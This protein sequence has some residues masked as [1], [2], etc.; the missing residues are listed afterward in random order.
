MRLRA[1]LLALMVP[2]VFAAHSGAQAAP[3][4]LALVAS[5]EP[6]P[7]VCRNGECAAEFSAFCLQE[8]RASPIEGSRY[9]LYGG[10]GVRIVARTSDGQ[11]AELPADTE[12]TITTSRS[13]T[14]VRIAIDVST[15]YKRGYK[16]VAVLVGENISLLPVP[17]ANDPKPQT[18]ADIALATGPLRSLGTKVVDRAGVRV[19]AAALT[20]RMRGALPPRG[21]AGAAERDRLWQQTFGTGA[22]DLR[23]TE[24]GS[25]VRKSYDECLP[26][27]DA[28]MTS[29]RD[30]LGAAHDKFIGRLNTDYWDATKFGF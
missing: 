1:S 9:S 7:M 26:M 2:F 10:E 22:D 3:Q 15:V 12:L 13:H 17:Y 4:I 28:G 27:T 24:A 30:C 23:S 11:P 16:Q 20:N 18:E 25:M 19:T 8:D 6:V 5:A 29:L 14:M 21:R